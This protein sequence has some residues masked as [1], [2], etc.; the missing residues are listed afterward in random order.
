MIEWIAE[1]FIMEEFSQNLL[2]FGD[3]CWSTH[4]DNIMY[5]INRYFSIMKDTSNWTYTLIEQAVVQLFK[6]GTWDGDGEINSMV[7]AV[8]INISSIL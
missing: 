3:S 5:T 7:E 4:K 2:D 6:L 1:F 8:N